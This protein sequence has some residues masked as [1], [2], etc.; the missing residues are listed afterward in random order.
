MPPPLYS[1]NFRAPQVIIKERM[2][3]FYYV[4]DRGVGG[5]W[6]WDLWNWETENYELI[7][8]YTSRWVDIPTG[9][10]QHQ[11]FQ[12]NVNGNLR[13]GRIVT[14]SAKR[15]EEFT[16]WADLYWSYEIQN[17]ESIDDM[18]LILK[19]WKRW[20]FGT[21]QLAFTREYQKEDGSWFVYN[22][23][24][25]SYYGCMAVFLGGEEESERWVY[26][27]SPGGGSAGETF[28][29]IN[30]DNYGFVEFTPE[31][32]YHLVADKQYVAPTPLYP[33]VPPYRDEHR[34]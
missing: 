11:G 15:L 14:T 28:D 1:S 17:P 33:P 13:P 29:L 10:F 27:Y 30:R 20:L 24:L 9:P 5:R 16:N 19:G 23:V 8:P 31:D 21:V 18:R 6:H 12:V 32:A 34:W 22:N 2:T 26:R 4:A 3:E 25:S 7:L